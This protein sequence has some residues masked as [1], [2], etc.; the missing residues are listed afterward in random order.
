VRLEEGLAV[1]GLMANPARAASDASWLAV[2]I[3]EALAGACD[4]LP[5]QLT[6]SVAI[7]RGIAEGKRERQ[8]HLRQHT[9]QPPAEALSRALATQAPPGTTWVAGGVYRLVR[10]DFVWAEL[11]FMEP[12][13]FY[14]LLGSPD[15]RPP[16]LAVVLSPDRIAIPDAYMDFHSRG[17]GNLASYSNA[18]ADSILDRL[19]SVVPDDERARLYHALQRRIAT[20]V[21]V[22]Y[23]VH[24]PR[25]LAVRP[26]LRDVRLDAN[27][28]FANVAE[29]WIPA[30]ERRR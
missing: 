23:T 14:G 6:A 21:P 12:S 16:A 11:R 7:V 20:D 19:Q 2:D 5:V 10:R 18:A 15:T 28:P 17:E 27:G 29:W 25:M 13:A 3:H 26:R 24:T 30:S 8:G 9:L 1:V 4:G 22:L